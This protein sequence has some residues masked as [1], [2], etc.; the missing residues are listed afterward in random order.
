M[1]KIRIIIMSMLLFA[2][3]TS[4]GADLF[5]PLPGDKSMDMLKSIFGGVGV[6]G[7]GGDPLLAFIE[8]INLSVIA[9][10]GLI[11]GYFILSLIH[12]SAHDGQVLGKKHGNWTV[13][14]MAS[15]AGIMLPV[16]K[17]YTILQ[18]LVAWITVQG[19]GIAD[20]AV[21]NFT[22]NSNFQQTI[23]ASIVKPEAK[24]LGAK[25]FLSSV[26]MAVLDKYVKLEE[27][28]IIFPDS[29]IGMTKESISGGNRYLFGNKKNN[30]G[31]T[32]E[33]C[34]FL[35]VMDYKAPT[36]FNDKL[37]GKDAFT[38]LKSIQDKHNSLSA[39]MV[40]KMDALASQLV[41]G[42]S[43]DVSAIEKIIFD[44]ESGIKD[45][46]LETVAKMDQYKTIQENINKDGWIMLGFY[47]TKIN[48]MSNMVN[49]SVSA[50]PYAS[51]PINF[52]TKILKSEYSIAL[53][54]AIKL[55]EKS[56]FG[57]VSYGLI[58]E[59][60]GGG[61]F[62][63]K[64][65]QWI[66]NGLDPTE[67]ITKMFTT[68]TY[69]VNSNQNPMMTL[70]SW[71]GFLLAL[72][73]TGLAGMITLL[74]TIG[75]A[76]G[77]G[78][79]ISFFLNATV[80]ILSML[81]GILK[82]VFPMIP[83]LIWIGC[84]VGFILM[85]VEAII[86]CGFW[87]IMIL[88]PD[89][90]DV[91]GLGG[92]GFRLMIALLFKPV[93]LVAG[94]VTSIVIMNTF[95]VWLSGM[96]GYIFAMTQSDSGFLTWLVGIIFSP[97]MYGLIMYFFVKKTYSIIHVLPD[98]ILKWI[99]GGSTGFGGHAT[100]MGGGE[101]MA[102]GAVIGSTV[103]GIGGIGGSYLKGTQ[104]KPLLG[105]DGGGGS[106]RSFDDRHESSNA[107]SNN[108]EDSISPSSSSSSSNSSNSNS[109]GSNGSNESGSY[110]S[111]RH[112]A[113]PKSRPSKRE[114][115]V[116]DFGHAP[117]KNNPDNAPSYFVKVNSNGKT[118]TAWGVDLERG[119]NENG[120]K[121]GDEISIEKVRRENGRLIKDENGNEITHKNIFDIKQID[122]DK[123]D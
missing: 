103:K 11:V 43:I 16:I 24:Q 9:V 62:L 90:H 57:V 106:S 86:A 122:K 116:V 104:P 100:S 40:T 120:I 49:Q 6:F 102:V 17:G 94:F 65:K 31:I 123:N 77:I 108:N 117:Y 36:D 105:N 32:T 21:V 44:Y 55:L 114:G 28:N 88:N 93:L 63:D 34:G 51:G 15:M 109:I 58:A 12:N 68:S 101:M 19:I 69:A 111:L 83:V 48:S 71:G 67:L 30:N 22:K 82:F 98:E 81:G 52:P 2:F 53:S 1:S 79:A 95:G 70:N 38:Q 61:S 20:S 45:T 89:G 72:A 60:D 54:T 42:G 64:V 35:K 8:V 99:G 118:S 47:D 112:K 25:L 39:S 27:N 59:A 91:A 41:N 85:V 50:L 5:T 46:A 115:T 56:D 76:P 23:S 119:I 66:N 26:C 29:Q 10:S 73:G 37:I 96:F 97:I 13:I 14:R 107:S 113:T 3:G 87:G 84:I 74:V 78:S 92:N 33:A 75:N 110:S 121:V 4:Y 18:V 80:P 7:A